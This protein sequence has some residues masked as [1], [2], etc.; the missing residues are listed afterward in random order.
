[1]RFTSFDEESTQLPSS[2]DNIVEQPSPQEVAESKNEEYGR[3][4]KRRHSRG[5]DDSAIATIESRLSAETKLLP[6]SN[7]PDDGPYVPESPQQ[8]AGME[9]YRGRGA[10]GPP[11]AVQ[12][13]FQRARDGPPA[14]TY[15]VLRA[16]DVDP[17][18]RQDLTP[19]RPPSSPERVQHS[20]TVIKVSGVE[21]LS[22]P[23]SETIIE[24]SGVI[25]SS[26]L[27]YQKSSDR[28][29][30]TIKPLLWVKAEDLEKLTQG[31]EGIRTYRRRT[32]QEARLRTLRK[33]PFSQTQE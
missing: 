6:G 12:P 10:T 28:Y 16:D 4:K 15:S 33:R 9:I 20:E 13:D 24:A 18:A 17:T 7:G 22:G 32:T 31:T 27:H 14:S 1:V 25:I 2:Q 21:V 3:G 29:L 5:T 23:H 19:T 26:V 11:A 8:S 30:I